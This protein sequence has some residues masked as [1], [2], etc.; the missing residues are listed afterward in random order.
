MKATD[1]KKVILALAAGALLAAPAL[2]E[3]FV[4]AKPDGSQL[5]VV[6]DFPAGEGPFAAI[7]LAPGQGY[8]MH[9]PALEVTAHALT[10]QGIAVFRFNWTYYT[11][12]PQGQPSEDLSKELQDLQAVISAARKHPNVLPKNIS[13][14]GKSLGTVVAWKAFAAD[15]T[16]RSALF[17]TP[18][19]SRVPDGGTLPRS[20]AQENYPGFQAER[21]PTLSISGDKDSLCA[22][23]ML[24]Q[25]AGAS[26]GPARVA[27]VGGD[28]SFENKALL[29]AAADA[30]RARNIVAVSVVAAGFVAETAGTSALQLR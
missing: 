18:I 4:V 11:A 22:P 6:A 14:G 30:A 10:E 27:I 3:E 9:L 26:I 23:A 7:V 2:A 19:C 5:S 25:F 16:L 28:H 13:V 8:H 12:Q 1:M 15:P 29:G 24:Y 21:R 17:I 20:E